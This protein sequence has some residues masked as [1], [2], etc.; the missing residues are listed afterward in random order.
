[1]FNY[2]LKII[3]IYYINNNMDFNDDEIKKILNQ[4]A[5]KRN[6]EKMYYK[7]VKKDDVE[8]QKLNRERAKKHYENNKEKKAEKYQNNK[9]FIKTRQLYYYY[10]KN[11]KVDQMIE[12]YP[13]KVE[14]LRN[15][16]INVLHE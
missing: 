6:R 5:K 3:Y 15:K 10:K 16:G 2:D 14:L 13:E 12:K 9:D 8:F 1:M 11:N 4:Y 7:Q